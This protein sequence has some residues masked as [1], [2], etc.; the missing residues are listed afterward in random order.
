[1]CENAMIYNKPETIY[2]KAAKK[3]LHSGMKIL[4][5]VSVLNIECVYVVKFVCKP[6]NIVNALIVN[7][8]CATRWRC[9]AMDSVIPW[10]LGVELSNVISF[11]TILQWLCV[12][13]HLGET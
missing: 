13:V 11:R 7:A 3:L 12:C 4:S 5:T 8:V 10:L 2:Y 6:N 1:M 9:Y